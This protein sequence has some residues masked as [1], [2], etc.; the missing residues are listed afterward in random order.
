MR[1]ITAIMLALILTTVSQ[2]ETFHCQSFNWNG[3]W[4]AYSAQNEEMADDIPDA[5]VGRTIDVLTLWVGEW[6]AAWIDPDAIQVWFYNTDCPPPLAQDMGMT[7]PWSEVNPVAEPTLPW[8]GYE[9]TVNLP[10][11][12]VITQNMSMGVTVVNSWGAQAPW[13]GFYSTWVISDCEMYLDS[14]FGPRW[15]ASSVASFEAD[16]AYC[17][18]EITTSIP[19]AP[20]GVLSSWGDIK[21]I[22]R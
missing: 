5:Y 22:F 4:R 21:A 14:S 13:V 10:S 12:V 1:I 11:P 18:A 19:A 16:L 8:G 2:A 9:I 3:V 6:G 20:E 17:L 15:T 7:I